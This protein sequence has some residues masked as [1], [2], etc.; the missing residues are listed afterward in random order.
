MYQRTSIRNRIAYS[1]DYC[2]T[3]LLRYDGGAGSTV[4]S[5]KG[6]HL[7]AVN[8]QQS[9]QIGIVCFQLLSINKCA[10]EQNYSASTCC[11]GMARPHRSPLYAHDANPV[12]DNLRGNF[13]HP[14]PRI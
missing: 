11:D 5:W 1:E 2:I 13:G 4:P 14:T 6:V 12:N 7:K 10:L 9:Q 8:S 3:P